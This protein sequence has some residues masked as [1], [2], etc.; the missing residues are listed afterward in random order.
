MAN[1]V[2]WLGLF[3]LFLG[4]LYMLWE[5]AKLEELFTD[6]IL[7]KLIKVL[8][9]VFLM[10]LYS[11]AVLSFAFFTFAPSSLF[12]LLPIVLLWLLSLMYAI[13]TMK[14]TYNEIK[15]LKNNKNAK[16]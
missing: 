7:G 5:G 10:V 13:F 14:K 1:L 3:S 2:L 8:I 4:S 11:L 9:V 16:Q 6:S 12:V 15:K